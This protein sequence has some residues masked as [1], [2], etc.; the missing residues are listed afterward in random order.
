MTRQ[1]SPL[2][3]SGGFPSQHF[4]FCSRFMWMVIYRS[5]NWPKR[6]QSYLDSDTDAGASSVLWL[7]SRRAYQIGSLHLPP[8][9][10]L[11]LKVWF[12]KERR[13][14]FGNPLLISPSSGKRLLIYCLYQYRHPLIII[15]PKW[16]KASN[17]HQHWLYPKGRPD[18]LLTRRIHN[19][20]VFIIVWFRYPR[21]E[22]QIPRKDR[23]G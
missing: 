2:D 23:S 6:D 5:F 22:Q 10:D 17:Q 8:L 14:S 11:L 12:P 9:F 3:A 20:I 19:R 4:Y 21:N 1:W 15:I 7:E 18:E 16:D 13:L